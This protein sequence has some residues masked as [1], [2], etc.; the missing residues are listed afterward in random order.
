MSHEHKGNVPSVEGLVHMSGVGDVGF[1]GS[2]FGGSKGRSA[3][4]EGFELRLHG[5]ES[6]LGIEYMCHAANV[7]DMPYQSNGHFQGSRGQSRQIEGYAVRLT[8]PAASHYNVLYT[9][10]LAEKGDT[11]VC[12]NGEYCGTKGEGRRMEGIHVW[13]ERIPIPHVEGLVHL[14]GVGDVAF[15][16]SAFAGS[17]GQKRALEGF[18]LRLKPS[19]HDLGIEYS[20]HAANVGDM[21]FTSGF[22]GSR[23]ASRQIEGF[24]I[25]LTGPLSQK[26]SVRYMAHIAGI[27]D[28]TEVADGAF[29]GTKGQGRAI[30]GIRVHIVPK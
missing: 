15:T 1:S 9:A 30:E 11:H 28:V 17:K 23:G 16:D 22:L 12:R 14:S 20:C 25:R 2:Q 18:E 29:C 27:G 3:A 8:G 21:P 24:S 5:A 26:Y 6:G 4:L 10:H 19:S 13:L 7:G